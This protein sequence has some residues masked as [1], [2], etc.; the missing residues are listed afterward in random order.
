MNPATN[1]VIAGLRADNGVLLN[2][3][4]GMDHPINSTMCEIWLSLE[5]GSDIAAAQAALAERHQVSLATIQDDMA[6]PIARLWRYGFLR[7]RRASGR[8]AETFATLEPMPEHRIAVSDTHEDGP[9]HYAVAAWAGFV[10]AVALQRVPFRY[11]LRLLRATRRLRSQRPTL[12]DTVLVQALV[13]RL[14]RYHPGW[15]ACYEVSMGAFI[16]LALLGRAPTLLLLATFPCIQL[17]ACLE[18]EGT[19]VDDRPQNATDNQPLI[20]I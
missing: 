11:R 8:L 2:V 18:A 19:I 9:V 6:Q 14:A 20:R 3:R 16:A 1:H 10:L 17:H 7:T 13:V 5:T 4:T 15:V 12:T